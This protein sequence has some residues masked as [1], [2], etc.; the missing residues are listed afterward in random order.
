MYKR[1]HNFSAGPAVLPEE[2]LLEVQEEML[3]YRGH[4]LSVMEMSHRSAPF[5]EIID[6]AV[7]AVKRI[8]DLADDYE[9]LFLQG[10]ASTQFY[11][12]PLNL[13]PDGEVANYINTGSWAGK[14]LK[15]AQ[16]MGKKMHVAASSEDKEFTY[17][18][19]DFVLSDNPAYLH[20]TTNNTIR[21]TEYKFDPET[22]DIPLIADM[23]SNFM[24]KPVNFRK[25]ALIYAGAQ[26]NIGPAGVTVVIIRKDIIPRIN[27]GLPTMMSY[28]THI[29]KG[30]MFNTPPCFAIYVTGKVL[31]W[32]E[33][34][35]GLKAIEQNN[36]RKAKCIYDILDNSRFY[37]GTVVREDRSM[38]NIPFRLPTEELEKKFISESTAQGMLNLKGHRS[39]G[40]CR[41]SLYNSL[42]LKSAQVLAEFMLD[43]EKKNR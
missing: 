24:S 36:I 3:D 1:I 22:G 20:I 15:E 4:G 33:N 25:Y 35:G 39:V 28:N 41:A 38:M 7:A 30:S 29:E 10:G 43:F 13:C 34:Q 27:S 6:N 19:R 42:P 37:R 21:G 5:Q 26:K 32:I 31:K 18:P 12:I 23:S 9:V 16:K 17:I 2:V 8:M 14:A 40:G 11:M